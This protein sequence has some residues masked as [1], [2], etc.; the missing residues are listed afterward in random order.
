MGQLRD[1]MVQDLKLRCYR[2]GTRL[3]YLGCAKRFIAYFMKPPT[4]LGERHVAT[5]CST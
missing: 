1:R 3:V 4:E 5:S 2:R